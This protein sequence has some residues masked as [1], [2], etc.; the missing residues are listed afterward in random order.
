MRPD[1][2]EFD[3]LSILDLESKYVDQE[4]F[5]DDTQEEWN[6]E[7]LFKFDQDS[8]IA[9]LEKPVERYTIEHYLDILQGS[10]INY[11]NRVAITIVKLFNLTYLEPII[12]S[13]DKESNYVKDVIDLVKS[14]KIELAELVK[15][16][17]INNRTSLPE[18]IELV[19]KK[20]KS[21]LL[22][23]SVK[24]MSRD[25]YKQFLKKLIAY[26]TE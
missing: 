1:F 15:E 12:Y 19:E 7:A 16:G 13:F 26:S 23:D 21:K 9:L 24:Y 20:C 6:Q 17:I 3:D 5:S 4:L 18:M 11:W 10:D 22:K 25:T 8:L 2:D 14:L